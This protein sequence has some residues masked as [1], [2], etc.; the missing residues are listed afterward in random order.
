MILQSNPDLPKHSTW[1][2]DY[3][4]SVGQEGSYHRD[5]IGNFTGAEYSM[6]VTE[7]DMCD[8]YIKLNYTK[9]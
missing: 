1:E 3:F 8:V 9:G 5:E 7:W 6:S 2:G 4:I